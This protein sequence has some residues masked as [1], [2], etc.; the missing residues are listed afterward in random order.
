MTASE[1]MDISEAREKYA[2]GLAI[3]LTDKQMDDQLLNSIRL[4]LEPYRTGPI[5]VHLYYKREDVCA[6][7]RLC[8]AW[9]VKPTENLLHDLRALVGNQ[10]VKLEFD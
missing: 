3:S 7:L 10:Q 8:E 5:P 4:Y 6:R 2:R 1:L 9:R